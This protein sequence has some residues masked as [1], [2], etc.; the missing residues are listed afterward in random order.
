[1]GMHGQD[2][3]VHHAV[4]GMGRCLSTSSLLRSIARVLV[5]ALVLICENYSRLVFACCS[6]RRT[7]E[8][9]L[10]SLVAVGLIKAQQLLV[11]THKTES[12]KHTHTARGA[13]E[14]SISGRPRQQQA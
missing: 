13:E 10:D 7:P 8:K 6:L 12:Q 9:S 1:M 4:V 5:G 11:P 14:W 3:W 2:S